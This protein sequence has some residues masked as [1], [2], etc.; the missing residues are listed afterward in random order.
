MNLKKDCKTIAF[1]LRWP[2]YIPFTIALIFIVFWLFTSLMSLIDPPQI[3]INPELLTISLVTFGLLLPISIFRSKRLEYISEE[4]RGKR[5]LFVV[6]A[7]NEIKFIGHAY[8]KEKGD[9]VYEI[10]SLKGNNERENIHGK[11]LGYGVKVNLHGSYK[12][13]Q[14]I[15][16]VEVIIDFK[17]EEDQIKEYAQEI[18]ESMILRQYYYFESLV[19]N[20]F[21]ELVGVHEKEIEELIMQ[22]LKADITEEQ[23]Q[24]KL[25]PFVKVPMEKAFSGFKKCSFK[26]FKPISENCL[27]Y[28]ENPQ[29][30]VGLSIEA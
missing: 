4:D 15:V 29:A 13:M 23:L 22:F 6:S 27:G 9:V 2:V 8:L 3:S 20:G 17:G 24:L 18:Y 11:H 19:V 28:C 30:E 10:M 21:E 5:T 16:P 1:F 7:S 25:G 12:T 14:C 26:I